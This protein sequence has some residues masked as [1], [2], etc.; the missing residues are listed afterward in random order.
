MVIQLPLQR[1][2]KAGAKL[3]AEHRFGKAGLE[4]PGNRTYSNGEPLDG[5]VWTQG[6][7]FESLTMKALSVDLEMLSQGPQRD[8]IRRRWTMARVGN[9]PLVVQLVLS[10]LLVD[11]FQPQFGSILE[12]DWDVEVGV[13]IRDAIEILGL[14]EFDSKSFDIFVGLAMECRKGHP[15]ALARARLGRREALTQPRGWRT[16]AMREIVALHRR[17]TVMHRCLRRNVHRRWV[18]T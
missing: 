18:G 4:I 5:L 13:L 12:S 2:R 17:A 3:V 10:M 9:A 8:L 15:L 11:D 6:E 7:R 14:L 16:P 1:T